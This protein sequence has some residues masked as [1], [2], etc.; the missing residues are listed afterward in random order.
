MSKKGEP[1]LV[2]ERLPFVL[3]D[4]WRAEGIQEAANLFFDIAKALQFLHS[5]DLV[6]GDVKPDN[7]GKD[8]KDYILLDFGIC[9]KKEAF[10]IDASATGSLRTRSPEL[11]EADR[12]MEYPE[13]V[14]VWALGA[15]IYNT[16][17]GRFPLFDEGESPPRVSSPAERME[18]EKYLLKR[19]QEE[20]DARVDLS[21]IP[22]PLRKLLERTLTKDPKDR[23]SAAEIVSIASTELAAFL[24]ST[25]R[26]GK[27]SPIE[28]L[29]QYMKYLPDK[30]MASLMPRAQRDSLKSQLET[31]KTAQGLETAQRGHVDKLLSALSEK[32]LN[33]KI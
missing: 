26:I 2:E 21:V 31:L 22:D 9:R 24:R 33:A 23:I 14:D 17:V 20:W 30:D 16:M 27:F 3:N 32:T 5:M 19:V 8:S 13:K 12:Y 10:I 7:I 6:H 25:Q 15:T 28:E 11:L 4:A 18:A 29:Q 1:F